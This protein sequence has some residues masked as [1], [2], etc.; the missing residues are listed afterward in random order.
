MTNSSAESGDSA[1]ESLTTDSAGAVGY[2]CNMS[3]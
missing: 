1:L 3:K 2:T